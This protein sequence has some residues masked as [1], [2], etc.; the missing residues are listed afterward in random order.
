MCQQ[1]KGVRVYQRVFIR[2]QEEREGVREKEKERECAVK[3]MK[4]NGG[5]AKPKTKF[6]SFID[7]AKN[8]Q[9]D[10]WDQTEPA[11]AAFKA[12][13][14]AVSSLGAGALSRDKM[15]LEEDEGRKQGDGEERWGIGWN[16]G[17][18]SLMMD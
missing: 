6:P 9:L 13:W 2:R 18:K 14:S 10:I 8:D 7:I 15:Y 1:R 17:S 16:E 12:C 3:Q 11:A 4:Q 5:K